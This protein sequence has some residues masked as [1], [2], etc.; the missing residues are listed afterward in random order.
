MKS[1][2]HKADSRGLADHGWLVSRHTFSFADYYNPERTRFGM[3]IVLNDDVVQPGMGFGTHPHDNMEI[4]SIPLTGELAHKDSTGKKEII[5]S[6]D[7]QIMSAGT[8]LLHSEFN[9]SNTSLVN[10]LQIWI[11]P[12]EKNITPRYDQITV[13]PDKMKNQLLNI[14]SPEK[15]NGTLWINQDAY[16]S[17][18]NLSN[19]NQLNYDIKHNGNGLYIFVIAGSVEINGIL[20]DKRDAAGLEEIES[21]NII[22]NKDSKILLIEVPMKL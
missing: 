21:A 12:K 5:K 8:G 4:I 2:V 15:K 10:F 16:I 19:G 17:L 18:G 20:L 14:I 1:I 9:N 22:S 6:G 11:F 3:L 13:E 7:V